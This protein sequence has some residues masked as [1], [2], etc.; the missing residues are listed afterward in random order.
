M[1][2]STR[3]YHLRELEI[4]RKAHVNGHLVPRLPAKSGR[5]LDIGCGAG[6]TM[7]A[8]DMT[9]W[10]GIGID[11]DIDALVLGKEL[12]HDHPH[13]SLLSSSAERL[14]FRDQSFDFVMSRVALPYTHIPTV[15]AEMARVLRPGGS[16][17]LTL[18]HPAFF[19]WSGARSVRGAIYHAY[20]AV[21]TVLF[22]TLGIQFRYPLNRKRMESYQLRGGMRRCLAR[23]G[24]E[25]FRQIYDSRHFLIEARKLS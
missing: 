24:F 16:I 25:V 2:S 3:E 8:I 18:H 15:I 9:G 1:E 10:S 12:T 5:M 21:N 13:L 20:I 22:H 6:Q 17:W 19:R 14:P 4:A 23:H 11:I 7:L